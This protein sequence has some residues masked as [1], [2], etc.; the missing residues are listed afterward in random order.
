M[1][2][3]VVGAELFMRR[4][5]G[6]HRRR[7]RIELRLCNAALLCL[8]K[9]KRNPAEVKASAAEMIN[10][11]GYEPQRGVSDNTMARP[12]PKVCTFGD[13]LHE[14][15]Q[16]SIRISQWHHISRCFVRFPHLHFHMLRKL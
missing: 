9:K 8:S 7:G 6:G 15:E 10:A 16:K 13:R 14:A 11:H 4:Y 1:S 3:S 12:R 2:L 5:S